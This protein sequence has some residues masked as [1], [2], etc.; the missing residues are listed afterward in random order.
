M[1]IIA[2][3]NATGFGSEQLAAIVNESLNAEQKKIQITDTTCYNI[4]ARK[5][6][7]WKPKGVFKGSTKVSSGVVLTSLFREI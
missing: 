4:L 1:R 7:L 2:V 5:G 3:R 6:A